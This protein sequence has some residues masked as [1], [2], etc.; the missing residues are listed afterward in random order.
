MRPGW[1]ILDLRAGKSVMKKI[2]LLVLCLLLAFYVG[3][4]L[5]SAY[6][7]HAALEANDTQTLEHKVD[8]PSVRASLKPVIASEVDRAM[9]RAAGR[10]GGLGQIIGGALKQ[11]VGPQ[12]VE[13]ILNAF[14]TPQQVGEIYS[15]RGDIREIVAER[16]AKKAEGGKKGEGRGGEAPSAGA[17]SEPAKD[18]SSGAAPKPREKPGIGNIKRFAFTGPLAFEIGLAKDKAAAVPDITAQLGFKGFDWKLVGLVP[19]AR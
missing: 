2:I 12:L 3:W 11:Q 9:E 19:K 15:R 16:M 10:G 7:I 17:G 18:A 6:R 13:T 8:F 4:P 5:W 1:C 14:V